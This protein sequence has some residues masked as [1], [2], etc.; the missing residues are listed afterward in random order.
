MKNVNETEIQYCTSCGAVNKK[1]AVICEDCKK[2]IIIRHRPVVDFLKKRIKNKA[3]GEVTEKLF[4]L[5]REF[6]FEHLY[7]VIL[8][9]SVVAVTT[10][11]V[12][13]TTPYIETV[14]TPPF[15]KNIISE[16]PEINDIVVEKEE[17]LNVSPEYADWCEKHAIVMMSHYIDYSEYQIWA[18]DGYTISP[19]NIPLDEIYAEL[20]IPGFNHQGVHE[21][22]TERV[23]LGMYYNG[24][25]PGVS[26]IYECV[27]GSYKFKEEVSS[28]LGQTLHKE[29]YEVMECNYVISFHEGMEK[30]GTFQPD[31]VEQEI[32]RILFVRNEDSWYIAEE[33]LLSR[34]KGDTYDIYKQYGP[35][36]IVTTE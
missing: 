30:D 9:V 7:G 10:T 31:P 1:S 12:I 16:V 8:T 36:G 4:S 14:A 5:I 6:L 13:N 19:D 24:T 23:P 32:Y 20:A 28:V 11:A 15:E 21:L 17:Q 26:E 34:I 18:F 33:M 35:Y 25:A 2:K 27:E 29:G 22:M 3:T